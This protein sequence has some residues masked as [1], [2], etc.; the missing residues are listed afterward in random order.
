SGIPA[1]VRAGPDL[2]SQ[3]EVLF[4]LGALALTAGI[5]EFYGSQFNPKSLPQRINQVLRS[6][7]KPEAVVKAAAEQLRLSGLA[8]TRD[9]EARV[10]LAAKFV[11]NRIRS[12]R[13]FTKA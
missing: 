5:D 2:F 11:H 6:A 10:I 9:L 13:K 7:P 1:I 12:E 3:P 4:F 8:M